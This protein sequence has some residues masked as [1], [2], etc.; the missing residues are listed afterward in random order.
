MFEQNFSQIKIRD[1]K[2]KFLFIF[3]FLSIQLNAQNFD[4]NLLNKINGPLTQPADKNWEFLSATVTPLAIA[5]PITMF[6]TGLANNDANLKLKSYQTGASLVLS[7]LFTNGIKLVVKR[8]RPF[9]EYP[10]EIYRKSDVQGYSFP[11]GHTTTAF[12][13]ATSL[14]LSFPKWYVILPSY[15]YAAAVGY[16]RMYLGV[17][18]PTDVLAG[19]ISGIGV[20]LLSFHLGNVINEKNK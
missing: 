19:I 5:T 3:I 12:A 6:V 7:S 4:I 15:T 14:S 8:D 2:S 16:S 10:S 13:L 20:S 11:S 17:H 1:L 18:Y 9:K